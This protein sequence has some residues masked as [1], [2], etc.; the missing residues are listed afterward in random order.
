MANAT[1]L[2]NN[3]VVQVVWHYSKMIKKCLG[4]EVSR[5]EGG[6]APNGNWTALSA[7]V[8]FK[9][10]K[11]PDWVAKTTTVWPIQKFEWKDLTAARGKIYGYRIV[12]MVGSPGKLQAQK[13]EALYTNTVTLTPKRGSFL[14]YFNRGI[15]STQFV[16]HQ[17]KPGPSGA[18]NYKIL[19]NRID[20]PGDPLRNALAG[21]IIEGVESLLQ[22]AQDEGGSCYAALY[23]LNDP[24]LVKRLLG[25]AKDQLHLILSNTGSDDATN[26]AARQALHDNGTDITDRFLPSN[27]IGHNKF[28]VYVGRNNA[29]QAVLL[30][31]TNWTDTGLCAQSNNSLIVESPPLAEAYL[32]Y[33]K[34]LQ[35]DEKQGPELRDADASPGA[36]LKIMGLT[37]PHGFRQIRRS[38]E[39]DPRKVR[40][41]KSRRTCLPIYPR[42]FN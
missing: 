29:P 35:S 28:V 11:N 40:R 39:F 32:E 23:E 17:I 5:Q 18:P 3:D 13:D 24:E 19:S 26:K 21:Q 7:W 4:F 8:G 20:Q 33:W 22:R 31:S 12:P 36:Q 30:G 16:A 38:N 15:L 27:H 9:G 1:A 2:A 6:A 25:M 41:K 37:R 34:R 14:T 42:Y 10:E